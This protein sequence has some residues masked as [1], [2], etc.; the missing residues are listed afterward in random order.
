VAY[1]YFSLI[2]TYPIFAT[3]FEVVFFG[4]SFFHTLKNSYINLAAFLLV[5]G[6]LVMIILN[7]VPMRVSPTFFLLNFIFASIGYFILVFFRTFVHTEERDLFASPE[8]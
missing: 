3:I 1:W 5:Y 2:L 6:A 8:K 7:F 4:E